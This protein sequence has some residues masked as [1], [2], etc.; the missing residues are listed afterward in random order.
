MIEPNAPTPS[1]GHAGVAAL[2]LRLTHSQG[3]ARCGALRI[4]EAGAGMADALELSG[5]RQ[6]GTQWRLANMCRIA[7]DGERGHWQLLNG[8]YTLTCVLNGERIPGGRTVRIAEGDSLELGLLRFVVEQEGS[9]ARGIVP[10]PMASE[11]ET[12]VEDAESAAF[13]LRELAGAAAAAQAA[14]PDLEA[15]CADPFSMLGIAGREASR[16]T[17]DVIS[18]LLGDPAPSSP[19]AGSAV[20][21][22]PT[23]PEA[24]T[25][26]TLLDELHDEFV[27]VVR[28]PGQLAGRADWE[29][30]L[31]TD[32]EH[33]P[34]LDD[35][36]RQAEPYA[37]LRDVL[38]P[39]EGIDR[40]IEAFEPLAPSGLLD[41]V[42]PA[43]V[44]ALFAPA[45]ARDAKTPL[46]GLT[47][48]E[49]HALSP[50][51][52]LQLGAA[53]AGIDEGESR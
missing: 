23:L 29:G 9:E 53:R 42:E 35:L 12:P 11:R 49:H 22:P 25:P 27:R 48:R 2:R 13:N 6:S 4:P 38:L 45:L 33:A 30:L 7:W 39:R 41:T 51:S 52:H 14:S 3:E 24:D 26:R 19:G 21:A 44:L 31:R 10:R 47:R 46:P 8:S 34:S 37:L 17:G 18:A 36:R 50:D 15:S 16:S 43:D 1:M 20:I 40:L 32:L 28:D 5:E